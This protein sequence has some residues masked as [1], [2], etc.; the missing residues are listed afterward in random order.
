MISL[1]GSGLGNNEFDALAPSVAFNSN[2][3]QFLVVYQAED[4]INGLVEGKNEI[5]GQRGGCCFGSRFEPCPSDTVITP[6]TFSCSVPVSWTEPNVLDGCQ[7]VRRSQSA[8]PGDIFSSGTTTVRYV[9][10]DSLGNNDTCSFQVEVATALIPNG[11]VQLGDSLCATI[12]ADSYQWFYNGSPIPGAT[13][14][15]Y[16]SSQN[17]DYRVE[18]MDSGCLGAAELQNVMV[19]VA[20]MPSSSSFSLTVFPVSAKDIL[21]IRF[22]KVPRGKVELQVLDLNG[23]ALVQMEAKGR[24]EYQL[25][26]SGVQNGAYMLR[27]RTSE[28]IFVQRIQVQ[29]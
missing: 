25:D 27:A 1:A 21:R 28:N 3:G 4:T 8:A 13:Q 11:M 23:K 6:S 5:F 16:V 10:S 22:D 29:R 18:F 17:G 7:G 20:P 2:V 14:A 9:A 19:G 12:A 15:C 26:L 24:Q